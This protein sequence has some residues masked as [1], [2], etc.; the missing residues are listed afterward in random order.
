MK[1]NGKKRTLGRWQDD[2][3]NLFVAAILS[4]SFGKGFGSIWCDVRGLCD[5]CLCA[6]FLRSTPDFLAI[7]D[8]V[9]YSLQQ[10]CVL[11]RTIKKSRG[12]N[13]LSVEGALTLLMLERSFSASA[14]CAVHLAACGH[15]L[16]RLFLLPTSVSRPLLRSLLCC[17]GFPV[18]NV[19]MIIRQWINLTSW[20]VL[21]DHKKC[22]RF[23]PL[24]VSRWS[25]SSLSARLF[26][27]MIA[28]ILSRK[29]SRSAFGGWDKRWE[30]RNRVE[31]SVLFHTRADKKESFLLSTS[32][33]PCIPPLLTRFPQQSADLH[34]LVDN[35]GTISRLQWLNPLPQQG[36]V[37]ALGSQDGYLSWMNIAW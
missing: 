26:A 17:A 36:L 29:P 2:S 10:I 8:G 35:L 34:C 9:A 25:L 31:E 6:Y 19:S 5:L 37:A 1:R 22:F 21:N 16:L 18:S 7:A 3:D 33:Q 23:V 28:S 15:V 12:W 14:S 11:G 32:C 30:M 13:F 27:S 20:T 24:T 4:S